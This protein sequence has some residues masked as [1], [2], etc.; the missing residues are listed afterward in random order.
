M[1]L[2]R[3]CY[4]ETRHAIQ[5]NYN[6]YS[7]DGFMNGIDNISYIDYLLSHDSRLFEIDANLFGIKKAKEYI[8]KNYPDYYEENK[9]EIE[10]REQI[11]KLEYLTYDASS[12]I[13]ASVSLVKTINLLGLNN[14]SKEKINSI[15]NQKIQSYFEHS[16]P[17]IEIFFDENLNFRNISEILQNDIYHKLDKK[18][19]YAV[20]SSKSFLKSINISNLSEEEL[21]IIRESLIYTLNLDLKQIELKKQLVTLKNRLYL[22]LSK[23]SDNYIRKVNNLSASA[24]NILNDNLSSTFFKS[25]NYDFRQMY[26]INIENQLSNSTSGL[27]M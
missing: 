9:D 19:I 10:L 26:L 7:F 2:A 17:A 25:P 23:K 27:K 11:Y 1:S 15:E 8:L 3:T 6:P 18:V 4:H 5:M 12:H 22:L 14:N 13:D 21:K 16:K 20:F 24:S